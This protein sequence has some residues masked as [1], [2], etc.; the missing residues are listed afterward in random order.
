MQTKA[1]AA[2]WILVGDGSWLQ[3]LEFPIALSP[4]TIG[5]GSQ[6]GIVIPGKH[7]SREHAELRIQSQ[8]I[9][10]KDLNSANGTYINGERCEEGLLRAG[11][12]LSL[13]VCHFILR[14]P[15]GIQPA[16]AQDPNLT[17]VRPAP[18]KAAPR[19]KT[20]QEDPKRWRTKATSPGNRHDTVIETRFRWTPW[21]N[22]MILLSTLGLIAWLF[23]L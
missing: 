20:E 5:R 16:K 17:M 18:V 8:G 9:Q 1:K 13:D 2:D 19:P 14:G 22:A 7:L 3:G 10:V 12:K 11:D 6:C 4:A 23:S 15:R 21:I